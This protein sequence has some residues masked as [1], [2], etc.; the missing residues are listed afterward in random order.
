MATRTKPQHVLSRFQIA[1]F[2]IL[3]FATAFTS[4]TSLAQT[5]YQ[6]SESYR[7]DLLVILELQKS[8]QQKYPVQLAAND[9]SLA[10]VET[11]INE[12]QA[13]TTD[14]LQVF[15]NL[16]FSFAPAIESLRVLDDAIKLAGNEIQVQLKTGTS[17]AVIDCDGYVEAAG[18]L[19][20]P[21]GPC[22][23]S[24]YLA[25]QPPPGGFQFPLELTDNEYPTF[26]ACQQYRKPNVIAGVRGTTLALEIIAVVARRTCEQILTAAGVGSNTSLI[27]IVTDVAYL[28]AK[29]IK[30]NIGNCQ[31]ARILSEGTATYVRTGELFVQS[32]QNTN[33][34]AKRA[35][36]GFS[37]SQN[38]LNDIRNQ[39]EENSEKIEET[40][41][42]INKIMK[43]LQIENARLLDNN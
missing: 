13:L 4:Q 16:N 24:N 43:A 33:T 39:V 2:A 31:T 7:S 11:A 8:L 17:A 29:G 9:M 18:E 5:G 6:D 26:L 27:C 38:G 34:I 3:T 10:L 20:D 23:Q 28:V 35:E 14:E 15:Q 37:E 41:A 40:I 42:T 1:A 25:D 30:E 21:P 22:N 12:A 19:E 36:D 32:K